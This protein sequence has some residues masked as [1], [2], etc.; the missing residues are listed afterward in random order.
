MI[1]GPHVSGWWHVARRTLAYGPDERVELVVDLHALTA[2]ELN[3]FLQAFELSE[4]GLLVE[5]GTVVL[6]HACS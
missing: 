5:R 4:G 6:C 2:R 1:A 3:R